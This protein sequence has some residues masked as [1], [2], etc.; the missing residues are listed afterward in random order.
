M[1]KSTNAILRRI[2]K[3][4]L[5]KVEITPA[6]VAATS[7]ADWLAQNYQGQPLLAF[8]PDLRSVDEDAEPVRESHSFEALAF[9]AACDAEE[10]FFHPDPIGKHNEPAHLLSPAGRVMVR[11]VPPKRRPARS[12]SPTSN[13]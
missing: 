10:E 8:R 2:E 7:D 4:R 3:E 6:P 1:A 11:F 12:G 5:R 13:L 9:I